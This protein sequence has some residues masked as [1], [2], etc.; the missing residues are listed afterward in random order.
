MIVKTM[1]GKRAGEPMPELMVAWDE[2]CV[3]GF[4]EGFEDECEKARESW[5][6]ELET[7]RMIDVA[8]PQAALDA[9]FRG[10]VVPGTIVEG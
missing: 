8:I 2:Y 5:K 3:D 9:A 7:Y 4:Q 6:D 10:A 1:W